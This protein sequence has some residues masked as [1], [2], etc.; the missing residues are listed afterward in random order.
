MFVRIVA[1][2]EGC[3]LIGNIRLG[4]DSRVV[5]LLHHL[6][7]LNDQSTGV[8]VLHHDRRGIDGGGIAYAAHTGV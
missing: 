6:H 7:A 2:G 1:I 5:A 4:V 8:I 3:G